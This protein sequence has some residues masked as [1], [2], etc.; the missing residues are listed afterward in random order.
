MTST[1]AR[2]AALPDLAYDHFVDPEQA[3]REIR[4]ARERS[5]IALGAHGPEVLTYDLVRTVLRDDRFAVPKGFGLPA[6][7]I[8]SGPLWDRAVSS[9][10][11]LDGEAH[12]RLRRLV[13]K[14]FTPRASAR[15]QSA[16]VEVINDLL[17][18]G[19]DN[20]RFDMVDIARR[21]PIPIICALLGAP[22]EDWQQF[23]GWADDVLRLFG[24][25]A[26]RHEDMILRSWTELDDYVDGMVAKRRQTLTD[27]LL[28][29]LIRAEIDGDHLAHDELLMLA[30]GLLMA[31]TDTTRNQL[32]AAVEDLAEHPDQWELLANHPELAPLAVEELMRHRPIGFGTLRVALAD[33]DL[34]GYQV[35]VGG[36]VIVNTAAANRDPAVYAD[37]DRL[38]ITREGAPTMLTF[39]G[40]VHYCLGTHLARIELAEALTVITARI[41]TAPVFAKAPWKP[42]A[43]ITGPTSLPIEL[44]GH[45]A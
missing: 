44:P 39:G 37:P 7:G 15:M 12:L 10:L 11:C 8:T 21:Y 20:V 2:T 43:G 1:L 32:A 24:W 4:L 27:D 30:G 33:I 14:A 36:L 17:D 42:L 16:C 26:A 40:G 13:A 23:S 22:K 31:G 3:H 18:E 29:D 41:P 28:S 19:F 9:L 6:Q 38:D 34:N 35:P 25:E 45:A 5:P